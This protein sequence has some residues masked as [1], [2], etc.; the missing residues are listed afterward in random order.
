MEQFL[1]LANL[2]I[3]FIENI[4]HL[5]MPINEEIWKHSK[6]GKGVSKE[7]HKCRPLPTVS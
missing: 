1:F 3:Q 7:T 2:S 5:K 6:M 4:G